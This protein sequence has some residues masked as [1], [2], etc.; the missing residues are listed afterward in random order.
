MQRF[1][2]VNSKTTLRELHIERILIADAME[3]T[4]Q[5]KKDARVILVLFRSVLLVICVY[6]RIHRKNEVNAKVTKPPSSVHA[7]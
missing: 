1:T 6:N 2:D 7:L 4:A 3:G 5:F